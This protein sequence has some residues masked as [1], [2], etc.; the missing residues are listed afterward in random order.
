MKKRPTW[1]SLT[2]DQQNILLSI[3]QRGYLHTPCRRYSHR[4]LERKG[5]IEIG[6]TRTDYVVRLTDLGKELQTNGPRSR[7]GS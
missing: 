2:A 5:L 3:Q 6:V 1:D 7:K 4:A